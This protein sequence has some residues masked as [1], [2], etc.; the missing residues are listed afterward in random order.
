MRRLTKNG[1]AAALSVALLV[2]LGPTGEL[3]KTQA[4]EEYT[5]LYAGLTWEQYWNAENIYLQDGKKMSDSNAEPDAK[6]E[7]DKG[8]FDAVSRA[9]TAQRKLSV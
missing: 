4:A 6:G 7:T 8:A 3:V 9:T 2:T 5:Y 1:V